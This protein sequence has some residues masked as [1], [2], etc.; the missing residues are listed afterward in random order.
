MLYEVVSVACFEVISRQITAQF[1]SWPLQHYS[2]PLAFEN[3]NGMRA[4]SVPYRMTMLRKFFL[5]FL[6]KSNIQLRAG[7]ASGYIYYDF[8][9]GFDKTACHKIRNLIPV[10]PDLLFWIRQY[11]FAF[12]NP[13]RFLLYVFIASL[14]TTNEFHSTLRNIPVEFSSSYF[15]N[16]RSSMW[17]TN[18]LY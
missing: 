4:T 5:V 3:Q 10:I 18:L 9:W 8:L 17:H 1:P 13:Q 6:I 2:K 7:W 16:K 14:L 15:H 11:P 12:F